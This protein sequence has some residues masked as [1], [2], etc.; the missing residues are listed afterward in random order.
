M[1]T[2]FK[3]QILQSILFISLLGLASCGGGLS[4]DERVQFRIL[5]SSQNALIEM[6]ESNHSEILKAFEENKRKV[7]PIKEKSDSL[8]LATKHLYEL[9]D[10]LF[11]CDTTS[12][13]QSELRAKL[14]ADLA[15]YRADTK[16][17]VE[18][19]SCDTAARNL[20]LR[21]SDFSKTDLNALER[22][23]WLVL[24]NKIR[25]IEYLTEKNLL[26]C[27]PNDSF[28]FRSYKVLVLPESDI[29]RAGSYYRAKLLPIYYDSTKNFTFVID[30]DTF[31][32]ENGFGKYSSPLADKPGKFKKKGLL[33]LPNPGGEDTLR[34][35]FVI[36]YEV[37]K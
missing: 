14:A 25:A 11:V 7:A 15:Q 21:A 2:T 6:C 27:I 16:R 8:K 17:W 18:A 22:T 12:G 35:P 5:K 37:V 31:V 3:F 32:S 36:E 10:S 33:F 19:H 9:C 30:N 29:V 23:D 13:S 1:K 26:S 24:Q 28:K 20:W 34:Y 4:D